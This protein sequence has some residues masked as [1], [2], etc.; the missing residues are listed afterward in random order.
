MS[1]VL[2]KAKGL[3]PVA[4]KRP[5][6]KIVPRRYHRLF[7]PEWH[8]RTIGNLPLWE[9]LGDLQFSFLVERG[10]QPGH[11]LLDVGCGPLRGGLRF[12]DYLEAGRY[13]GIDKN[14]DVLEEALRTEI[15]T[16]GLGDKR[17]T[18][19]AM[20]DFDFTSLGQ[21]FDYAIAQ[22]VFTHLPLNSIML[23]LMRMEHALRPGGQF[24]ATFFEN[25]GG[26]RNLADITQAETVVTHF[27]RDF[28][29]YDFG[30]FEWICDETSLK[31]EYV[32]SWDNPRN[33]K[34]LLFTKQ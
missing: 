18:L 11:Y 13:F 4:V 8:R 1:S 24:Y 27:D 21:T 25:A 19:R 7:D 15:P 2:T 34:M 17:P 31:A 16:S 26:K 20:D 30:T 29:H 5:V 9:E 22:S 3:V 6:K 32:G 33:Q 12:I 14:A 23:C 10:L 28:Y